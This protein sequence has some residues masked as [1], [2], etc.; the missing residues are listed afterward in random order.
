MSN[1]V[2]VGLKKELRT[3]MAAELAK[4]SKDDVARQTDAVTRKVINADWYKSSQRIS[5]YVSTD[6]EIQTDDIIRHA[7]ENGK[8]VFIPQF[9]KRNKNMGMVQLKTVKEF[10]ELPATLW[11]IRQPKPEWEWKPYQESGPLD[12]VLMPV[13]AFTKDLKRCGH[14]MGYY[15]RFLGQHFDQFG[16]WPAKIAL[17]LRE[18]IIDEVPTTEYDVILDAIITE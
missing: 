7:L 12:L 16:K 4:L 2:I 5:V 17:A 11:G 10:D 15:D 3:K 9:I 8:Q 6:G 1:P 13:V 18:Q 14:G